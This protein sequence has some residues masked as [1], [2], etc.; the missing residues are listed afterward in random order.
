[1]KSRALDQTIYLNKI[2]DSLFYTIVYVGFSILSLLIVYPFYYIVI[3]SFNGNLH[4][5]TVFL[6]PDTFSMQNYLNVL[7]D[8][9]IVR[10]LFVSILR[11][12]V[13]SVLAVALN[14]T[15]AFAL[16]KRKLKIRWFY[17][18]MFT[19][20][21]FFGGGLIPN[22]LI[23][24][25]LGLL[26]TFF[27]YILPPAWNFFYIIIFMSCF[28]DIDDAMEESAVMD[29]ANHLT[30]FVRIYAPMSVPVIVTI[31]LFIS[32]FHWGAWFDSIYFTRSPELQTLSAFL[33]RIIQRAET[34]YL[35]Q[36]Q[37][38]DEFDNIHYMGVRF[39]TMIVAIVPVLMVYPFIQKYFIRGI[40]LGSIKG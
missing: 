11:V 38:A 21:M 10:S 28:N 13:G 26:D 32:V 6:W 17:L 19:I 5:G 37:R 14:A 27:V 30:I 4:A 24:K 7:S 31:F 39:V 25:Y 16:R 9:S 1:M 34:Q 18:I 29:G 35:T 8:K 22:F 15:A 12:A 40:R 3:N 23:L 36:F 20:P 2:K 33:V